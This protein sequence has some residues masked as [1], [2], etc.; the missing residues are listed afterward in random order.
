MVKR[1][2]IFGVGLLASLLLLTSLVLAAS[3]SRTYKTTDSELRQ[4]MAVSLSANQDSTEKLVEGAFTSTSSRFVGVV[5]NESD[6]LLTI[7]QSNSD[8]IVAVDGETDAL[9]SDANG[10]VLPGDLVGL[11]PFKGILIKVDPSKDAS[12]ITPIGV[13]VGNLDDAEKE[14]KTVQLNDGGSQAILVGKIRIELSSDIGTRSVQQSDK[15]IFV[16]AGESLTGKAV[17]G[18]QVIAALVVFALM[19]IIVGSIVYGAINSAI[20]SVGRNPLAK[21]EIFKQILQVSWIVLLVLAFGSGII[22]VIM[23]I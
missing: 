13:A 11:S 6:S 9:V 3:I 15:N 2:T 4:G 19:I 20:K 10:S 22:Y 23:F 21:S 7:S 14:S 17:S 5:T 8:L 12:Q 18:T 16:V 1:V